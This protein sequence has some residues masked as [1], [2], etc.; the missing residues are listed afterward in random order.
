MS[1]H[2]LDFQD[3]PDPRPRDRWGRFVRVTEYFDVPPDEI[4]YDDEE[5]SDDY[6]EESD[7][8][9]DVEEDSQW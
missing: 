1:R 8:F 6:E 4:D 3:D 7:S 2:R 9:E 5:D